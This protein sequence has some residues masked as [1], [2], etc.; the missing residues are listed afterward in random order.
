MA[1]RYGCQPEPCNPKLDNLWVPMVVGWSDISALAAPPSGCLSLVSRL[2]GINQSSLHSKLFQTT[3]P[4][5][6][7]K[8]T[9]QAPPPPPTK[10]TIA[11][12]A[13]PQA[14]G[15]D[16]EIAWIMCAVL[17][18]AGKK[19][20]LQGPFY[21]LLCSYWCSHVVNRNA[22]TIANVE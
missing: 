2:R 6:L 3:P 12:P 4:P 9:K 21:H 22:N 7:R 1:L 13:I 5:P 11:K 8:L 14:A 15:V 10:L 16:L 20:A 18:D 19:A 17:S